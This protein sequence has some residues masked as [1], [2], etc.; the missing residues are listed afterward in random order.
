[1][2][3]ILVDPDYTCSIWC[4][5]L[6]DDLVMQ[7][8]QKR[9]AYRLIHSAQKLSPKNRYVFLIGS[10]QAWVQPAVLACNS[11]GINPIWLCNMSSFE[12]EG[13]YSI[14]CTDITRSMRKLIDA[15]RA[16][17][18]RTIGLYGFNP[19]STTDQGKR[20]SYLSLLG[21]ECGQYVFFNNGDLKGCF[22]DFLE[23]SGQVDTLICCNGFA[24]V[25]LVR[26]LAQQ[27][28]TL[29]E[30]LTIIAC[31]DTCL[32][33]L[34]SKNIHMVRNRSG[35]YGRAAVG[36]LDTLRRTPS[37]S[38]VTVSLQWDVRS[39]CASVSG[40]APAPVPAI[41][42]PPA[43]R[44]PFYQDPEIQSMMR[45]ERLL[46]TGSKTDLMILRLLRR[47]ESYNEIA[48]QLFLSLN[49]VKY[50]VRKMLQ[51][52]GIGSKKELIALLWEYVPEESRDL[53]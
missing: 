38:S 4:Q 51:L 37:L 3:H 17:G 42:S 26:R 11:L 31:T 9:L 13:E 7:L 35:E 19:N 8:K 2:I 12:M 29:L 16:S 36:L 1:M 18:H 22:D 33:R 15:L 24:A 32:T 53:I 44:D 40:A 43:E 21:Q 47:N 28:P 39:V 41:Q 27:S 48:E 34:Y 50:H 46:L 52:C 30:K 23:K 5:R 45:L 10:D 49:T 6:L 20:A 14:V 25:S